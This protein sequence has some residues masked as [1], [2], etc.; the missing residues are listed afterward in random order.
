[1]TQRIDHFIDLFILRA[2]LCLSVCM[3]ICVKVHTCHRNLKDLFFLSTM[4]VTRMELRSDL[5]TD[6]ANLFTDSFDQSSICSRT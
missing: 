2:C 6:Q 5:V 1:M 3:H 4:K